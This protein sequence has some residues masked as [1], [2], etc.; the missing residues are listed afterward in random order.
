LVPKSDDYIGQYAAARATA[1][2]T[3]ESFQ[4]RPLRIGGR[5]LDGRGIVSI[6]Q[7]VLSCCSAH[8]RGGCGDSLC[9]ECVCALEG[10]CCVGLW[11]TSCADIAATEC[12]QAC[13][14]CE[15]SCSGDCNGDRRTTIDELL[16]AVGIAVGW[17]P[18]SDCPAG[19]VDGDGDITVT[20]LIDAVGSAQ[21]GCGD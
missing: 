20:D 5:L 7:P 10:S 13:G 1:E 4:V 14:Q 9:E 8:P 3:Y 18:Q 19:D 6:Q 12:T 17:R 11:E 21:K 16:R 2:G 15:R